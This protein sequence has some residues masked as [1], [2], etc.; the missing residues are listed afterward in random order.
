MPVKLESY[1]FNLRNEVSSAR[2]D[3]RRLRAIGFVDR[4]DHPDPMAN[5]FVFAGDENRTLDQTTE[6]T[7]KMELCGVV[8][9][10]I[11][12]ISRGAAGANHFLIWNSEGLNFWSLSPHHAE[13]MKAY[14]FDH[15]TGHIL[16]PEGLNKFHEEKREFA[17]D[18][19]AAI[20]CF[21]R[22]GNEAKE[23]MSA[24][25]WQR[26]YIGVFTGNTG[27]L[28]TTVI[29]RI[30]AE[31]DSTDYAKMT[32]QETVAHAA[33]IAQET[34]PARHQ[35]E[36]LR[37]DMSSSKHRGNISLNLM[38][39]TCLSTQSDLSFFILAKALHPFLQP[40]GMEIND[41]PV[42]IDPVWRE[43][44]A[45]R[46]AERAKEMKLSQVFGPYAKRHGH[47]LLG[48][49]D[50]HHDQKQ[51]FRYTDPKYRSANKAPKATPP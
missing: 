8:S 34:L 41:A 49:I 44:I 40:K 12:E 9:P 27:H 17:A 28:T 46:L 21:Q 25:S 50:T 39:E 1:S 19:Y 22:F 36:A 2:G 23:I 33:R 5:P 14:A 26:A 4:Q 16:V 7:L 11:R 43:D 13:A 32:P 18:A 20:R 6:D 47:P 45:A 15:E 37:D 42:A 38:A 29:D 31:S 51:P 10:F 30:I 24:V 35:L 3:F 48:T